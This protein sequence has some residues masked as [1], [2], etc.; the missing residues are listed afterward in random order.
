MYKFPSEVQAC[1]S[2]FVLPGKEMQVGLVYLVIVTNANQSP[3][4]LSLSLSLSLYLLDICE[5]TFTL[6]LAA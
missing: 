3:L 4:S 2:S 5:V 1:V 6:S